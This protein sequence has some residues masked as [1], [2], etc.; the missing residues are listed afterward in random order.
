MARAW[1]AAPEQTMVS[2]DQPELGFDHPKSV[3]L[4]PGQNSAGPVKSLAPPCQ[5]QAGRKRARPDTTRA[6]MDQTRP[7]RA[8]MNQATLSKTGPGYSSQ[9]QGLAELSSLAR[10]RTSPGQGQQR[11]RSLSIMQSS[12]PAKSQASFEHQ[13]L[14][15]PPAPSQEP[16]SNTNARALPRPSELH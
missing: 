4:G 7:A 13:Y 16:P 3:L 15:W 11:P 10:A 6:S 5:G 8:R 9:G 1:P 2:Q 12:E 14:V